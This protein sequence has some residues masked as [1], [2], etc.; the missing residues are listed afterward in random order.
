MRLLARYGYRGLR[1]FRHLERLF[2]SPHPALEGFHEPHPSQ[3]WMVSAFY[4]LHARR[5]TGAEGIPQPL[6]LSEITVMA[7]DILGV[8]LALRDLFFRT[9]EAADDE[10]MAILIEKM[11]NPRKADDA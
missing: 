9:M 10:M 4:R 8:P 6:A 2:G 5:K 3:L 1:A 11:R 7:K